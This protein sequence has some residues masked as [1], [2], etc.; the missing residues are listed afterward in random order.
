MTR[1]YLIRHA[2]AEGNLY[3][4]VHGH[5]DSILTDNGLRQVEYLRRRFQDEK[6]DAVY[7]SDLTRTC[8]TAAAIYEPKGLPLYTSQRLREVALGAW[9]DK[10]WGDVLLYDAEQYRLFNNCPEK[11]SIEGGE[12]FSHV[13]QRLKEAITTIARRHDG[14]TVAIFSHGS[15]IRA[16]TALVLD[17]PIVEVG[18]GDNTSVTLMEFD[19]G[20]FTVKFSGDN[21]H[22]P[23]TVSTLA[24][25]T[26]WKEKNGIDFNVLRFEPVDPRHEKKWYLDCYRDAWIAA[27]GTERGFSD[28]YL[29]TAKKHYREHPHALMKAVW[30]DKPA[31][32]VELSVNRD[33][34][35]NAGCIA[36]LYMAP[37]LRGKNLAVQLL[38]Q[39]VSDYHNLGRDKLRLNVAEENERAIKFYEKY[40]FKKISETEGALGKLFVMEKSI[41]RPSIPR[42]P[43]EL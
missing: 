32:L 3:R 33:A 10:P 35:Q 24:R 15:A 5:Y 6:I 20:K 11:W 1:I 9:E 28:S 36:F 13:Q 21:S 23:D 27:H 41:A 25:Q 7:S 31:G 26:W 29:D 8:Q 39:A 12:S 37:E 38:G 16:F 22:L 30:N 42:E 4:R 2:E 34:E 40:G 17:K 43:V 19:G 14:G 18:H